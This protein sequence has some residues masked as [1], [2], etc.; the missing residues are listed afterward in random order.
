MG[1]AAVDKVLALRGGADLVAYWAQVGSVIELLAGV[2]VTGVAMGLSVLVAQGAEPP[3]AARVRSGTG[4]S[5][6]R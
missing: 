3:S 6:R 2:A 4:A 5:S 1:R